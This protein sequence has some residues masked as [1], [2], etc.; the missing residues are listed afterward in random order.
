[1]KVAVFAFSRRD[2]ETARRIMDLF[3]SGGDTCVAFAMKDCAADGFQTIVPPLPGYVGP[4]F[5]WADALVFVGDCAAAVRSVAP[6]VHGEASDPA[7][8]AV[9]GAAR[10][11]VR[12]LPGRAG[13]AEGLTER[14]AAA[15]RAVPVVTGGEDEERTFSPEA[16]AAGEGLF[17]AG[18]R[19]A[20]AVAE[21]LREGPVPLHS[22]FPVATALPPGLYAGDG[23][24]VGI[25]ISVQD[26]RPFGT[27]LWLVPRVLRIGIVC[28]RGTGAAGIAA[29]AD[30]VLEMVAVHTAAVRAA[31]TAES[32]RGEFGLASFCRQR[33]WPLEFRSVEELAA[34][35][36][37][38]TPSTL[39]EEISGLDNVCERAA[40]ADGA[41]LIVREAE[42]DGVSVALAMED[43]E[44]RF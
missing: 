42:L 39:A 27:T 29:V 15:L 8:I 24:P 6:H 22:D 21:A 43:W 19:E 34:L 17:V 33:G 4:A 3:R 2:V 10:Y 36:G 37:D 23:G 26:K 32:L 11:A 14:L 9:D 20:G 1:M 18:V 35:K 12:L 30:R 38:F 31:A 28:R 41:R 5:D 44:A 7:V 16:W 25:C 13:G 40:V